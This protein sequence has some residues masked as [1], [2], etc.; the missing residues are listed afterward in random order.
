MNS[1]FNKTQCNTLTFSVAQTNTIKILSKSYPLTK[2]INNKISDSNIVISIL[3][4]AIIINMNIYNKHLIQ[5]SLKILVTKY[6]N[7]INFII[8]NYCYDNEYYR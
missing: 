2:K 3:Y 4:L 7:N 8:I 1:Q 5:I 6:N